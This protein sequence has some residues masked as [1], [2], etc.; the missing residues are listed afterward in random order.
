MSSLK[1][2]PVLVGLVVITIALLGM[3]GVVPGLSATGCGPS[4]FP[5]SS[6]GTQAQSWFT[7]SSNNLTVTF[8]D[9]SG[10]SINGS[11]Y[12]CTD[13]AREYVLWEVPKSSPSTTLTK[14]C[15]TTTFTYPAAGNYTIE[16]QTIGSFGANAAK[17][18]YNSSVTTQSI[19]VAVGTSQHNGSNG[20]AT[21][22]LIPKFSATPGSGGTITVKDESILVNVTNPA[23]LVIW[24]DGSTSTYLTG[25]GATTTHTYAA[26]S[27]AAD[28]NGTLPPV[29]KNFT[30]TETVSGTASVNN[31]SVMLAQQTVSASTT[32]TVELAYGWQS[33]QCQYGTYVNGTGCPPAPSPPPP[34]VHSTTTSL[35]GLNLVTGFLLGLGVSLLVLPF[36][37]G[38]VEIR[39]VIGGVITLVLTLAGLFLGGIGPLL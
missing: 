31:Y 37:P 20:G 36:M 8:T 7:V 27:R 17:N 16:E 19:S 15:T 24:G 4:P 12:S 11:Y 13:I 26:P 21:Y 29:T 39:V 5:C 22:Q 28:A 30:V 23:F 33:P 6:S 2:I 10:V 18:T 3:T 9:Q 14:A 25:A 32:A 1:V 38:S 35:F 34:P